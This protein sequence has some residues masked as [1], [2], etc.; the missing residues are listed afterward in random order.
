VEIQGLIEIA[1]LELGNGFAVAIS[2][3]PGLTGESEGAVSRTGSAKVLQRIEAAGRELRSRNGGLETGSLFGGA[4]G[5]G[6]TR[7]PAGANAGD[8]Q[9]VNPSLSK[10]EAG[11][12]GVTAGHPGA[13]L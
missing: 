4:K 10:G 12:R 2:P 6:E 5:R 9:G 8:L 3:E 13:K 11:S 1:E 7:V